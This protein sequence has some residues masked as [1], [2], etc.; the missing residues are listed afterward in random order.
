M[1]DYMLEIN[2]LSVQY[3]TD[4]ETVHAV[5]D[6][7]LELEKGK[8]LGLVGETGAGKT[9]I[10]K[11]IMQILPSRTARITSGRIIT[12]GQDLLKKSSHELERMRG[13]EM[14]MI[15]QDPMS[16]LNPV[17]TIGNQIYESLH[18]HNENHRSKKELDEHV[19]EMFS[20]VGILPSRKN[21]YPHQFSG[22]MRQRAMIAMALACRPSL[23]IADEPTTA[24]DVTIQAQVL[25]LMKDLRDIHNTSM[26]MITHDLGVVALMCDNVAVMYAGEIVEYGTLEDLYSGS[27][28]HPYTTGLFGAIPNIFVKSERLL[29]IHG[30]MPDPTVVMPGCKFAPRCKH[31]F[32]RCRSD[33]PTYSVRNGHRI[34][35][36]LYD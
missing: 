16:S 17:E 21:E 34:L 20:L 26:L 33:K 18:Y 15:F 13:K 9:T 24:L 28:H 1:K 5:N 27:E 2:G 31:A 6:V 8:T 29:P 19:D 4:L 10:A 14:A 23:L 12:S 30:L 25:K 36:H 32:G 22:G 3:Q 11:A 7:S 35:C